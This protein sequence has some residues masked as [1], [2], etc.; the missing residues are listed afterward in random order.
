MSGI[1]P[2]VVAMRFTDTE[3]Q[4]ELMTAGGANDL[5]NTLFFHFY[6]AE[7][8]SEI[9]PRE[10]PER[11][12]S[13]LSVFGSN[14]RNTTDLA[15][16]FK[17]SGVLD[18]ATEA[19]DVASAVSAVPSRFISNRHITVV[20]P[21]CPLGSGVGGSFFVEVSSN[22]VDFSPSS[23][24]P[25]YFYEAGE[26]FIEDVTPTILREDG[27][28]ILTV[29]GSGFPETYSSALS[30]VFGDNMLAPATRHTA[31]VLT[32]NAPPRRPGLVVVTVISNGQIFA[33]DQEHTVEYISAL[34][35]LSSWP[36]LGP[37]MGG[38]AI[39]V[40][41]EGFRAEEI[42][43]CAFGPSKSPVGA[44][45]VNVSA[46]TCHAPPV[47]VGSK[48]TL[49]VLLA[50]NDGLI[51]S[52]S[53]DDGLTSAGDLT[54]IALL[55]SS[56][57]ASNRSATPLYFEY[58]GDIGIHRL[59]PASGPAS[60]GTVVRVSGS[61]FIDTPQIAC[62]FGVSETIPARVVDERTLVCSSSSLASAKGTIAEA[63]PR[64]Y[65]E[66]PRAEKAV[67]VR[68][69]INGIDF[70][71]RT[72]AVSFLYDD[73]I[74]VS[75]LVPNKGPATGGVRVLVHGSGFREDR[76]LACRFGLEVVKAEQ[77]L[78]STVISCFA[79]PQVRM[80]VVFV[81]VTLNGQD[82][83]PEQYSSRDKNAYEDGPVFTYTNR[84]SVVV[85]EPDQGPTRGGTIVKVSGV[86]FSNA[87]TLL[88]RFGAVVTTAAEFVS[89]ELITCVSPAVPVTTGSV[90]LEIS[91]YSALPSFSGGRKFESVTYT[92][93]DTALWSESG[94]MFTFREDAEVLTAFP[95]SGPS[96]G[97]T[98][99]ILTGSGFY[100]VPT[101]GCRFGI[102]LDRAGDKDG[103]LAEAVDIP[104]I[105]HS[106]TEVVC[107][108][109][110]YRQ[111]WNL[112]GS[113]NAGGTVRIAASFDGQVYGLRMAQFTYFPTP[114][115][116]SITCT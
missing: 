74:T 77:V 93:I 7:I 73:D 83:A 46:L 53:Y 30:C 2:V 40:H 75:A 11:G 91:D 14:F 78:G 68:V 6:P 89:T 42:Y 12:G 99:V 31:E 105:Y 69:T 5:E 49:R 100:D 92:G 116:S 22:G 86:N 97:G 104:A 15:V 27:G 50:K 16:R 61:G 38:T 21:K 95:K 102:P 112:S 64:V 29:F 115:V 113:I 88:C 55:A 63:V 71:P 110:E 47:L 35:I 57:V 51:G 98:R 48:V 85:L 32:C 106:Y 37:T 4:T 66:I 25:L 17:F 70:L 111:E 26:P 9:Q 33:A 28:V 79:P 87:S 3:Y 62:R 24:G 59:N 90:K 54:D 36:L 44:T 107:I 101:L 81:S 67:A 23:D 45:F 19:L 82:F 18:N 114:K 60:G 80:S 109:P 58:H 72:G 1:F 52:P 8:V 41:G 34:R 56:E 94:V 65:T 43:M 103:L 20:V 10:G 84:P 96:S 39:T 108:A 76:N 13:S